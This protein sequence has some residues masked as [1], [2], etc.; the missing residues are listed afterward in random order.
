MKK[1]WIKQHFL[2]V[3]ASVLVLESLMA[4]VALAQP[5]RYGAIATSI[6]GGWGYGYDYPT[7][8]EAEQKA[9]KECAKSDCKVQV[10]FKNA[11]G[12]VAKSPEG[13]IGWGWAITKEQAQANALIECGTGTCK[14]ETWTCTTR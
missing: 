1:N 7:R 14:I 10:W 12:A 11:C 13:I 9:L 2:L 6:S 3:S 4:G 8:K 5:D